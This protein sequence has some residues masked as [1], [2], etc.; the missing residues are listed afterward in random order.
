MIFEVILIYSCKY[1]NRFD[2]TY[3]VYDNT[4]IQYATAKGINI[5]IYSVY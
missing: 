2:Q 3:I 1:I 4:I 5:L